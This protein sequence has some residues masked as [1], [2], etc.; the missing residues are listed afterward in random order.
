MKQSDGEYREAVANTFG[1]LTTTKCLQVLAL[2]RDN[3]VSFEHK[4]ACRLSPRPTAGLPEPVEPSQVA[5]RNLSL[6]AAC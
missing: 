3:M 5:A 6:D 1:M 4:A 2:D